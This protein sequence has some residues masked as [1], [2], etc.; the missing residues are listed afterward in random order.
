MSFRG[1]KHVLCIQKLDNF[2][3]ISLLVFFKP[4]P[5]PP[6]VYIKISSI[7]KKKKKKK[8]WLIPH[9][10]MNL[11]YKGLKSVMCIQE[12]GQFRYTSLL[13]F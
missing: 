11:N 3:Y 7:L 13:V 4:S 8:Q 10:K 9:W 2:E 6:C 5:L 1:L 12:L